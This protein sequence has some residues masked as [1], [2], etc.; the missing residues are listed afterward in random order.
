M[1]GSESDVKRL[2]EPYET[3]G[4]DVYVYR[5]CTLKVTEIFSTNK[6]LNGDHSKFTIKICIVEEVL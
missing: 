5:N 6:T 3:V 1:P 4:F 2:K